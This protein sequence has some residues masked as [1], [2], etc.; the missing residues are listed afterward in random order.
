MPL[1]R[2]WRFTETGPGWL[3]G[4]ATAVVVLGGGSD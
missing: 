1:T 3:V 2:L 4:G